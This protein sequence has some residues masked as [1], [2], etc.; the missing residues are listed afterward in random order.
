MFPVWH[1]IRE[2]LFI[3][4]WIFVGCRGTNTKCAFRL[5]VGPGA[6]GRLEV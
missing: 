3:L 6:D 1:H 2:G 5:G 4:G